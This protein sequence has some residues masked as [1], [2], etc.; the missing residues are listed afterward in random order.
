MRDTIIFKIDKN[1]YGMNLENIQRIISI[2]ELTMVPESSP[3]I[4]GMMSYESKVIKVVNFRKMAGM[5]TH[6]E[7]LQ[8]YFKDLKNDHVE[9]VK[10]LCTSI[11]E[12][13]EFTKT[14]DPHACRLGKWLDSFSS[15]DD[16]V[17]DAYRKL[18][19]QHATLHKSAVG[20][21]ETRNSDQNEAVHQCDTVIQGIYQKTVGYM[22]HFISH[23]DDISSSLQKLLIYNDSIKLF[24]IKVDAIEDILSIDETKIRPLDEFEENGLLELEGVIDIDG[25]LINIVKSIDLPT[26][27]VA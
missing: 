26:K 1:L 10:A 11:H 15:Y 8:S 4:D 16:D 14:T 21:L 17:S 3:V 5:K 2:P 25:K 18:Y 20:I 24:G 19:A 6:E 23:I 27:K 7:E 22:D 12:G 9:W 13:G